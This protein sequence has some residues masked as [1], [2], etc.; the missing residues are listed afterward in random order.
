MESYTTDL[1]V[2]GAGAAGLLAAA[3]ARRLGDQV[4]VVEASGR[5]GG[6]T[7]AGDGVA[8]LPANPIMIKAGGEDSP[9]EVAEYLTALL[10][11]PAEANAA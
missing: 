6:S 3:A 11:D 9:T 10:G 7:T 5:V 1:V 8:W 2:V 4:I